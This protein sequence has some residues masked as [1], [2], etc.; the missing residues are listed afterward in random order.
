MPIR[1]QSPILSQFFH[2]LP[3]PRRVIPLNIIQNPRRQHK[4]PAINIRPIPTRLLDKILNL[5][6][7]NFQSPKTPRRLHCRHSR[8]PPLFLMKLM[9][10]SN[11]NI[12]NP[13]PIRHKEILTRRQMILN[14]LQPP[15][16]HRL[17]AGIHQRHLP[18]INSP[19]MNFNIP[20]LCIHRQITI[21]SI[22]IGKILL[23]HI[24]LIPKTDNK[25][26]HPIMTIDLHNVPNN[27]IRP[28]IHHR[29]RNRMSLLRQPSP[30]STC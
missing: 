2:R 19:P 28:N 13:I 22:I 27:R 20:R 18:L 26:I 24:P 10:R 5:A 15:T 14:S 6:I 7:F 21:M 16:S 25:I 4:E 3:L 11:I 8:Q 12:R 23:Q 17:C 1:R 29:L 30:Q 9:Q